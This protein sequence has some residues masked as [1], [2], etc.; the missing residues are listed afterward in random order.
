MRKNIGKT[1][2]PIFIPLR[3]NIGIIEQNIEFDWHMGMSSEV[4]K[5]SIYS[6]H[7]EAKKQGFNKILEASSKSEQQ[8][9]IQLSAFFLKNIKNYPVENLF[10]S[11]KVFENGGPYRDLLTVTP[12]EAKKD[13]RLRE[14]G[15]MTKF[16]FNGKDFPLEPKSLFYDWLYFNVLFSERNSALREEFFD[17][18]FDA[19]SDIE[20][21]PNKSFSCQARTLALCVSLYENESVKD[22]IQDPVRFAYEFELYGQ[23]VKDD[24]NSQLDLGF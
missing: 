4:R 15:S 16:S 8:I 1:A 2:R 14:S 19:F 5:R 24:K 18:H 23:R 22:F 7:Q 9:G 12:R 21:I 3:E 6:L 11:S 13:N 20:F 17:N 10:K